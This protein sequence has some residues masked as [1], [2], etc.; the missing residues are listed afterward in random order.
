MEQNPP[1]W[2]SRILQWYCRPE[3]L[4]DL[5]GDLFEY[6][7]RNLN[8]GKRMA[9]LIYLVDI[10]KFCR[11]YTIRKPKLIGQMNF[12]S[13][14]RNYFLTSVR[15]MSR[16]KL[17]TS[18]NIVGLAISMSVGILMITYISEVLSFDTFHEKK[19]RIYRVLTNYQGVNN[20]EG[21]DLASTSIF[22]GNKLKDDYTGVE[23]L[24]ILR[25]NLSLDLTHGDHVISAQGLWATEEFFKVF[26]F[27]L[28]SGD[29]VTALSEPNSIIITESVAKKMFKDQNPVGLTLEV[30]GQERYNFTN[31]KI[32]GVVKDPP[33]NSHMDFEI[34]GSFSTLEKYA[35]GLEEEQHFYNSYNSV[36]MNY[37]Y[38]VVTEGHEALTVQGHLDQIA[39]EEGENYDRF[40]I[41][42]E[43]ENI[44][45]IMPG[46]DL[47]NQIGQSMEW[48]MI[49]IFVAL[50]LVVI[51]SAGFNYTNLSI[52][53]SLR[54]AR[55][56][57]IRKIV[58]AGKWHVFGQFIFEAILISLIA[59]VIAYGVFTLIK[60]EFIDLI[61]DQQSSIQLDF[62]WVHLVYFVVFAVL[63]GFTA[64][65]LPSLVLSKLKAISV[66][67]DAGKF[68][69]LR[70]V[71]L[72]RVL[73]IVQFTLSMGFIIAAT[74]SYRQ[75]EYALNFD[76]GFKTDNILNVQLKGEYDE[77][78]MNKY[79]QLPEVQQISR[80]GMVPS[81]G[82]V[83]GETVKYKDPFDS[84]DIHINNV[85]KAYL[86]VHDF[87]F[88]AGGT[89]PFDIKKDEE[90]QFMIINEHLLNR[91]GFSNPNDAIGESL[92]LSDGGNSLK[93]VG[94]VK[95]FQH[96]KITDELQSFAFI[97]DDYLRVLNLQVNTSDLVGLMNKL[98]TIWR[99][100]D[101][102][103]PFEA[104]FYND[105]IQEAYQEYNAYY[106]VIGF[107]AF[108]TIS[109]AALGLLGMAVFT[110]ETRLKEI[111]IRKVMGASE[112]NLVLLLSRGF[113]LM[114]V[115]SAVIAIPITYYLFD[116][117][118]L[119]G[120]ANRITFGAVELFLGVI[121]IFILGAIT[122][123]WQ[124]FK[125]ARANP[126]DLLRNE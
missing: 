27:D 12:F 34:L 3:I 68:K 112:R 9:D 80:S 26:S 45:D 46:R 96:L 81:T 33:G 97:Q 90:P 54:R 99:E 98:E 95:D 5:Q 21:F 104:K 23:N 100:V 119:A 48:E 36:W 108:L 37:V 116:S 41:K 29:P 102:V 73:I 56:V 43:L 44:K 19:D 65:F 31:A 83:W 117:V 30:A 77:L 20:D 115:V 60:P 4:E 35:T 59:L 10:I 126:A 74:I 114:M 22:I 94:V 52:A 47:S 1:K 62:Q 71:N 87:E 51:I 38:L 110:T 91:F 7:Q 24:V 113:L 101:S 55:E 63:V 103:H 40:A 109:I 18:I 50:T 92:K 120:V 53:R 111:S 79:A 78:L 107:L 85:D 66:L 82:E 6:Y 86:E 125:A 15:S 118:V 42:Y 32:S 75:Y 61:L 93:I 39:S 14:F 105:Q 76:L 64:G 70:G 72:R 69:L 28:I 25:R 2:L 106:K 16:S 49:Y 123:G 58:G 122:I 11:I 121:L 13:M 17:F 67:K 89:F 124:T 84:V 57:G 8:R 88:L